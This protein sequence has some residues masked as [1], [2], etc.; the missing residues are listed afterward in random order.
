MQ[1]RNQ[2]GTIQYFILSN[3]LHGIHLSEHFH[4]L[5]KMCKRLTAYNI[6][7]SL[8]SSETVNVNIILS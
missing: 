2:M 1:T 8:F 7:F 3:G 6:N 4:F 5:C